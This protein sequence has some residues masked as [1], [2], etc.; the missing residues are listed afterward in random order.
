MNDRI[1]RRNPRA[2]IAIVLYIITSAALYA[3][4]FKMYSRAIETVF[5]YV[6]VYPPLFLIGYLVFGKRPMKR[7]DRK[8]LRAKAMGMVGAIV[9][10]GCALVVYNYLSGE[11]YRSLIDWQ[12]LAIVAAV[13]VVGLLESK[14]DEIVRKVLKVDYISIIFGALLLATVMFL[15]IT[16]PY[17]VAGAEK[18][19]AG[20]GR[21]DAVFE[22]HYPQ[23][24]QLPQGTDGPLGA[25]LF[26]G[27]DGDRF[28]VDVASGE[29]LGSGG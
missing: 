25:Y 29:L 18:M 5:T 23:G 16:R 13:A 9:L 27:A 28:L 12:I 8:E 17:T 2:N 10:V 22:E 11:K 21:Q 14:R 15:L 6:V 24:S 1:G 7:K 19:L 20:Y 3:I 4:E 26:V